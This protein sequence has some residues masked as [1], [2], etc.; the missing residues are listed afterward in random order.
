MNVNS[1]IYKELSNVGKK[2]KFS[3]ISDHEY[4]SNLGNIDVI[5]NLSLYEIANK[6]LKNLNYYDDT[7]D[8]DYSI[9]TDLTDWREYLKK[10]DMKMAV[11]IMND[12]EAQFLRRV[13][14]YEFENKISSIP[15]ESGANRNRPGHAYLHYEFMTGPQPK[16]YPTRANDSPYGRPID[17]NKMMKAENISTIQLYKFNIHYRK[18]QLNAQP[19]DPILKNFP[20]FRLYIPK[21]LGKGFSRKINFNDN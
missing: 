16:W 2:V 20:Y 18:D 8:D 7:N 12:D 10:D 9:L 5:E 19:D 14:R 6:Y 15:I 11:I 4:A 17:G 13:D 3:E 1:E 21:N